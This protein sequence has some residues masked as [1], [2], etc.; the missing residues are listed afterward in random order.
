MIDPI[1][2]IG[3]HRSGTSLVS[4][5]LVEAGVFMGANLS[6]GHSESQFFLSVNKRLFSWAHAEWDNPEP[7]TWMMGDAELTDAA[8]SQLR[9]ETDLESFQGHFDQSSQSSPTMPW[10][11]KDPRTSYTL[12][13]WLKLFPTA[14]VVH[15]VRHGVDVAAS[16]A[17]REAKRRFRF[18]SPARSVRC[19]DAS[20]AFEL[21]QQYVEQC[22]QQTQL[23]GP[24]QTLTLTYEE[25]LVSPAVT[26]DRLLSFVG[27][28]EDGVRR[29]RLCD[30]LAQD[31][32]ASRHMAHQRVPQLQRMSEDRHQTSA[33]LNRFYGDSVPVAT[34]PNLP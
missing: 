4:R 23:L 18:D 31:I 15:V 7:M 20:R 24:Q 2:V 26:L 1:V 3:M 28:P 12:P 22:E 14:K 11:W 25:L 9:L 10:G 33:V 21:W 29:T 6:G 8:I 34:I 17:A 13:L 27:V 32:D 5:K 19:L 16:L 30:E